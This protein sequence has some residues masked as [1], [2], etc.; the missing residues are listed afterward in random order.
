MVSLLPFGKPDYE[1]LIS[2]IPNEE[3]LMQFA[4]PSF[5]FPVT[6]E[7]LDLSFADKNRTPYKVLHTRD[8]I[9]IGHAEIVLQGTATALLS[10]VFIGDRAYRGKG[11]GQPLVNELVSLT[12]N[13]PGIEE[14]S[15]NVFD[16]NIPA[17]KSYEKAGFQFN[18]EKTLTRHINGKTWIAIN[19]LLGKQTWKSMQKTI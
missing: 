8:K 17:I 6:A 7:Q 4:G 18:R 2:W 16:W 9:I 10:R 13:Q 14:V 1:Q 12:F 3:M 5:H 11:L 15:L 19:M